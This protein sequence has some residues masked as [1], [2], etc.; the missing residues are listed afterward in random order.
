M[1]ASRD[2][3]NLYMYETTIPGG[4][5]EISFKPQLYVDITTDID[6]KKCINLF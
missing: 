4:L 6:T 3:D 2:I 5:T 1:S